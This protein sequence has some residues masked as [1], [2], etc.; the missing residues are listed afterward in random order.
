MDMERSE[1]TL[2]SKLLKSLRNA[3]KQSSLK[4]IKNMKVDFQKWRALRVDIAP[5]E[6]RCFICKLFKE[7][8]R[9][10]RTLNYS[11]FNFVRL[12]QLFSRPLLIKYYQQDHEEGHQTQTRHVITEEGDVLTDQIQ[13]VEEMPATNMDQKVEVGLEEFA[14]TNFCAEITEHPSQLANNRTFQDMFKV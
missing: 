4:T 9:C 5:D 10:S 7:K 13:D 3:Q 14:M 8:E 11:F 2:Q 1:D 6:L 12:T